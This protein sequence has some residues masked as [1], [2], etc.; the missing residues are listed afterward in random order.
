VM[1]SDVKGPATASGGA[2]RGVAQRAGALSQQQQ[3]QQRG[4][5]ARYVFCCVFFDDHDTSER[6]LALYS[7]SG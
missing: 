7:S 4:L 6:E 1:T 3:Q 2:A 5:L